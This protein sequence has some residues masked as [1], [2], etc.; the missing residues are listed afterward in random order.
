MLKK[1]GEIRVEEARFT[2]KTARIRG[3]NMA[4]FFAVAPLS[5]FI[6]FSVARSRGLPLD[7]AGVFYIVALL[8]IPRQVK[9]GE[10]F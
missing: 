5:T 4:L 7:V 3:A 9:S 10:F 6:V 8:A 1:L 2:L